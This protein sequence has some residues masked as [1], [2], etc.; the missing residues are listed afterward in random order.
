MYS[1][2]CR[3]NQAINA[4]IAAAEALALRERRGAVIGAGHRRR[5]GPCRSVKAIN[6]EISDLEITL[7]EDL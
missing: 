2:M 3:L 1:T 6:K 7:N 4:N 5:S